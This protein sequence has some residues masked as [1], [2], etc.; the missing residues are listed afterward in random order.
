MELVLAQQQLQSQ[1]QRS[2][3]KQNG[4]MVPRKKNVQSYFCTV[5]GVGPSIDT[6]RSP[7][8]R[9]LQVKNEVDANGNFI[10][11]QRKRRKKPRV[12]KARVKKEPREPMVKRPKEP[13]REPRENDTSTPSSSSMALVP[14]A[15]TALVPNGKTPSLTPTIPTKRLCLSLDVPKNGEPSQRVTLSPLFIGK[16]TPRKATAASTEP[17]PLALEDKP[18]RRRKTL[19]VRKPRKTPSRTPTPARTSQ[20]KRAPRIARTVKRK[21]AGPAARKARQIKPNIKTVVRKPAKKQDQTPKKPA[22][23]VKIEQC[24]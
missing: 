8:T 21:P 24:G 14:V 22:R 23:R 4:S 5:H 9:R 2:I 1:Y 11:T 17:A 19:P 3:V 18:K 15:K 10:S 20:R 7:A 12:R 16:S 13:R 6:N